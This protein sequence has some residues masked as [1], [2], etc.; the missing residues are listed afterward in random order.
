[1][2]ATKERKT[3][4]MTGISHRVLVITVNVSGLT[5]RS[6]GTATSPIYLIM[7]LVLSFVQGP[8]EVRLA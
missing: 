4:T 5:V 2:I 1:M 6:S 3:E 7:C 8:G